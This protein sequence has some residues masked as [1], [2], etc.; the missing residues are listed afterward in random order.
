MRV[1]Q[2]MESLETHEKRFNKRKQ[3]LIERYDESLGI[4]TSVGSRV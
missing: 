1:Y 2:P 3:T 4:G